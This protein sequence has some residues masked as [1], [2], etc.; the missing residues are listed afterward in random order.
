VNGIL[1]LKGIDGRTNR[2]QLILRRPPA[3]A[4]PFDILLAMSADIAG[5]P[6]G[7]HL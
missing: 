3:I 4:L 1:Q 5:P 6:G 2:K 7:L